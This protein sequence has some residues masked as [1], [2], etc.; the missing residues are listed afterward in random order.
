MME[1][2]LVIMNVVFMSEEELLDLNPV[3]FF[4]AAK[5]CTF[6]VIVRDCTYY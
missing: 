1:Q 3:V 5:A 4:Q 6:R 2:I